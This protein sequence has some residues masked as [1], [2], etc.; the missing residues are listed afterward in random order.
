MQTTEYRAQNHEYGP[1]GA[2]TEDSL[3]STEYR[4]QNTE[5]RRQ[6]KD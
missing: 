1:R 5:Y 3:E 4:L 6:S 2:N